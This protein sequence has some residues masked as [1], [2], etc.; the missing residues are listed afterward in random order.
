MAFLTAGPVFFPLKGKSLR[1]R[2]DE[3]VRKKKRCGK[4]GV[5]EFVKGES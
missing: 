4:N 5:W 2:A 3:V 1:L